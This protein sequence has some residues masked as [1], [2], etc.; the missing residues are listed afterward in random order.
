MNPLVYAEFYMA[1]ATKNGKTWTV[2]NLGDLPFTDLEMA[3]I[4]CDIWAKEFPS[5]TYRPIRYMKVEE[6][7]K[8]Q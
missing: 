7:H 3:Q 2:D 1:E 4:H 5:T 6:K 8:V